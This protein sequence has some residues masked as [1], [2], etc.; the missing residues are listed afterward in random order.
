MLNIYR[1]GA[2]LTEAGSIRP[3]GDIPSGYWISWLVLSNFMEY[4]PAESLLYINETELNCS[5]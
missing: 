1:L 5:I 4:F 3:G 2:E